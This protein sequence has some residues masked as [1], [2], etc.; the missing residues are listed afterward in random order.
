MPRAIWSGSIAFGLVNAPVRLY[1]AIGEH[2]LELHLVRARDGARTRYP[3]VD[4]LLVEAM[5]RVSLVAVAR[6]VFRDRERLG[7]L[8]VRDGV[9]LLAALRESVARVTREGAVV[10]GRRDGRLSRLRVTE[11]RERARA[12]DVEGR[13]RM[14]KQELV[15]AIE[16]A[17]G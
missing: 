17:G 3:K 4:A 6:F 11:L 12:L 13:S 15:D 1:P 16:A 2:D 14:G 10:R 7:S 8:R 9:L 5:E